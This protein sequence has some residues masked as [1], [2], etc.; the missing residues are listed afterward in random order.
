MIVP[1][2]E[3]IAWRWSSP[4]FFTTWIFPKNLEGSIPDAFLTTNRVKKV[5]REG[6]VKPVI[7]IK[8]GWRQTLGDFFFTAMR[9]APKNKIACIS[10][11]LVSH[12]PKHEF[13]LNG[14]FGD[15]SAILDSIIS[16]SYYV[17]LGG[18]IHINRPIL[19]Y[20]THPKTTDL[21]TRLWGINTEL[22]GFISRHTLRW[23]ILC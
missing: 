23:G 13:P 19:I 22:V 21:C 15:T 9:T 3:K 18:Q 6:F 7:M 10:F 20:W 11:F 2:T 12:R 1:S 4:S 5:Q 17:M 8:P 16:N 14:P